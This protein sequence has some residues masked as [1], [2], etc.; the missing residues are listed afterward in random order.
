MAPVIIYITGFRQHAGKTVAA[1]GLISCL[2]KVMDPAR[3]GFFK[4]VGQEMVSLANG[5]RIDKDALIVDTFS[6]MPNINI[7]DTSPVRLTSGFTRKYLDSPDP[8]EETRKLR[9]E[10]NKTLAMMADKDIIIAEGTGHPGVGSIVGLSNAKVSNL[11]KAEIIFLSAGGIG[12]ALDQLE[13]DISYFLYKKSRVRGIIFNKLLPDKIPTVKKYITE[14]LLNRKLAAVGGPLRI[15]GFLPLI[16]DL[17]NPSMNLI[18]RKWEN[19]ETLGNPDTETWKTPCKEIK[20][21]SKPSENLRRRNFLYPGDLI[22]MS[23]A[24][25]QRSRSILKYNKKLREHSR[26]LGGIILAG[27]NYV[28]LESQIKKEIAAA[29]LPALYIPEHMATCEQKLLKIYENTKLQ[30]YDNSKI[31]QVE[32]LFLEHFDMQKFLDTFNIKA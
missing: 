29:A 11:M 16:E 18:S 23:C 10:I 7:E 27:G 26:G 1:L 21:L 24:S 17:S 13:V 9:V 20:V 3:I 28:T 30:V 2:K 19:G 8:E 14:D 31:E 25:Q 22:I 5:K 32:K 4:P 6:G 12:R 15:L